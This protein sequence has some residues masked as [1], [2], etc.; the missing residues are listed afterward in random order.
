MKTFLLTILAIIALSSSSHAWW[1]PEW[2]LRKKI[3]VDTSSNAISEPIGTAPVLVR[4][5]D[6]NFQFLAAKE[7]GSDIRFV[8][9]DDK[10]PLAFHIE[11]YDSLLNEAFVWVK[12]PELKPNIATN[13]WLYYGNA[14]AEKSGDAKATYDADT[15]LVWHF[16]EKGSA[17][18]DSSASAIT[19]NTSGIPVEGSIIGSGLRLDGAKDISIPAAPQL[20]TTEGGNLTWSAWIKPSTLAPSAVIYSRKD[21]VN[22]LLIG[23]DNGVPYVEVSNAAGTQRSV[24]T[25]QPLAVNIWRHLAIVAG[26][27][28]I[29]LSLDGESYA[30]LGAALPALTTESLLGE[31]KT[32]ASPGFIGELDELEISKVARPVGFLKLAAISQSGSDKAAKLLVTAPDEANEHSEN[33]LTKQLSLITDI[34]KSLT[35]DGWIVIILCAILAA[36]GWC[37]TIVKF[38]YLGK[39]KKAN[40]VFLKQWGHIA[41]DLTA[42]DHGNKENI[43]SIGGKANPKSQR[44]MR[45]SPLYHIYHVGSE[46]IHQRASKADFKGLT[47]RSMQSI[48]AALDGG[49]TREVQDLNKSLIFLTIGIAGG[50]YLGLLGTVIG[51]MITFAVIAKTGQVE[52]NSIAPGIAGALLATVAGLVV[53]IPALFAYSFV[54]SKI[55]DVVTEMQIFIDEFLA[56]IA[57]FYPEK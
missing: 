26:G 5:H 53:A 54:S 2:T 32:S 12:I 37:V 38:L 19:A 22:A 39:I 6:G 56:K 34:S 17:P 15:V 14:A 50:P 24:A 44:L 9:G 4:L 45:Q 55:K 11:K 30:M 23:V 3:T 36:I 25:G 51:V 10:T 47:A 28:Q 7:D 8:A 27:S 33:E 16:A 1:K 48:K 20:N 40:N 18:A 29:T 41:G 13:I 52:V 43:Q 31:E 57:E 35:P 49:L 42:L 46:E 21:G